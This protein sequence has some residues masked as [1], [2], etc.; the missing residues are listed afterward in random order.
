MLLQVGRFPDIPANTLRDIGDKI[1]ARPEPNVV[2]LTSL[3][4]E[5]NSCQ[6]IVM[7]DDGAVNKG[8]NAGALVKEACAVLSGKGGGRKNL[9]Q[10][11]G[12]EGSKREEALKL[13]RALVSEQVKA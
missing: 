1:R 5:D 8:V 11:G 6:I 9:A 4:P 2:V 7:A 13:I 3:N 10:G 12:R